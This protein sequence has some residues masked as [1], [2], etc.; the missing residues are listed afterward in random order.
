MALLGCRIAEKTSISA[1]LPVRLRRNLRSK[2]VAEVLHV[3]CATNSQKKMASMPYFPPELVIRVLALADKKTLTACCLV[4]KGWLPIARESLYGTLEFKDLKFLTTFLQN[5]PNLSPDVAM[6]VR[7]LEFG[8]YGLKESHCTPD[9]IRRITEHFHHVKELTLFGLDFRNAPK[10]LSESLTIL[11]EVEVLIISYTVF[12]DST[13]LLRFVS[14]FPALT[15][16]ALKECLFPEAA[17]PQPLIPFPGNLRKGDFSSCSHTSV[18]RWFLDNAQRVTSLD[19]PALKVHQFEE[20]GTDLKNIGD[21]LEHLSLVLADVMSNDFRLL[22]DC[23]QQIPLSYNTNLRSLSFEGLDILSSGMSMAKSRQ[24]EEKRDD[25]S[26]L[27]TWLR[28]I[29]S[30]RLTR[31]SLDF[32]FHYL[33]DLSQF[34]WADVDA[35]LSAFPS[36]AEMALCFTPYVKD[37]ERAPE[38]DAVVQ[39]VKDSLPLLC[40]AKRVLVDI[41]IHDE[42]PNIISV[43]DSDESGSDFSDWDDDDDFDSDDFLSN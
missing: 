26:W 38:S 11:Q 15:T 2:S 37:R 8:K 36:L 30:F 25:F 23:Y 43:S 10:D 12:K 22:H 16:V 20:F 27:T 6:H 3:G 13:D 33:N 32:D 29:S 9:S 21:D 19:L 1:R 42:L 35:I 40:S 17:L 24:E 34:P 5:L 39:Y 28:T 7:R 41:E 14:S 4:Q 18:I 31:I